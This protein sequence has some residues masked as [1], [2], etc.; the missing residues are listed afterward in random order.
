MELSVY[1][2]QAWNEKATTIFDIDEN[3]YWEPGY[4][5]V[6]F[7]KLENKGNLALQWQARI[8]YTGMLDENLK[9]NIDVYVMDYENTETTSV[10]TREIV[11]T[12]T[13]A[14]TLAEF[15]ANTQQNNVNNKTFGTI[16]PA[17]PAKVGGANAEYLGVALVMKTT[18][19]NEC[20]NKVLV[21]G[22][23]LQ[24]DIVATQA[25]VEEDYFDSE[26]DV[27]N[28]NTIDTSDFKKYPSDTNN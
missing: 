26:Y 11:K 5:A 23:T 10:A 16:L 9:K 15:V 13:Y 1:E 4:T 7:F 18:A 12:W 28:I 17:A 3:E 20:Q 21:T 14:G 24:L 2:G 22:G 6:E 25:N 8:T 27:I 19:G